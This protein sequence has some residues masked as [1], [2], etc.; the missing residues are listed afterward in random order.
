MMGYE[1]MGPQDVK[2]CAADYGSNSPCCGQSEKDPGPVPVK[3]QCTPDAPTCTDYVFKKRMGHC[4]GGAPASELTG[5]NS[6]T[7]LVYSSVASNWAEPRCAVDSVN[8]STIAMQQP[9]MW[10][11]YHR[12]W[13]PLKGSPPPFIENL[14]SQLK[15]PGE[16]YYDRV[17]AEMLYHPLEG[18]DMA[19]AEAIVAVE[20]KLLL[21]NA[22]SQHTWEGVT[23]EYATWLRPMQGNGYVEQQSAA[24]NTW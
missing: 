22:S 17:N 5:W 18:Q 10:N 7:E 16:F 4:T 23:F 12:A 15:N 24:C 8:G 9:C 3:D 2:S 1:S 21:H 14:R 11:L 13:Q 6:D 20:E 19:K